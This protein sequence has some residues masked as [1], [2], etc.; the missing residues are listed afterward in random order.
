M[1]VELES[2]K[3]TQIEIKLEMKNAE[4]EAKI[5]LFAD[6]TVI[7]MTLTIYQETSTDEKHFQQCSRNTQ[8]SVA[9]LY[10][11]DKQRKRN[12]GNTFGKD[13][14]NKNF[15]TLEKECEENLRRWKDLPCSRS[16]L[17]F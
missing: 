4:K 2:L 8:Q 10:T 6:D 12:Q 17:I 1:T 13:L 3:R 14:Y 7:Y 16:E 9:F 15:R 5:V 11:N